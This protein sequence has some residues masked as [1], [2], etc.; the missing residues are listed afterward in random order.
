MAYDIHIHEEDI[1]FIRFYEVSTLEENIKA[2]DAVIQ[3]CRDSGINLIL[4]D[5]RDAKADA[6]ISKKDLY[7]FGSSWQPNMSYRIAT[8]VSV[9]EKTRHDIEFAD[10]VAYNRGLISKIFQNVDEAIDW[11]RS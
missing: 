8:V 10:T 7:D 6:T 11:L 5:W 3:M 2:R 9:D 1:V 4:A